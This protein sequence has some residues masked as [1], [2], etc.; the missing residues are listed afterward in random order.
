MNLSLEFWGRGFRIFGLG[1][2]L[3]T[4]SHGFR[5]DPMPW[6]KRIADGRPTQQTSSS[7]S[8]QLVPGW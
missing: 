6:L 5:D 3:G 8:E 4:N 7:H 2:V 1:Q